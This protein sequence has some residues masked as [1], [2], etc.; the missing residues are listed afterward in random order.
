MA[1]RSNSK[2]K[3]AAAAGA[4][5]RASDRAVGWTTLV[6]GIAIS[7]FLWWRNH[8]A[9]QPMWFDEY[10]LLNTALILWVPLV[11]LMMGLRREPEEFG[12]QVGDLRQ[13]MTLVLAA[14]LVFIPVILY[15]APDK[16]AQEYYLSWLGQ[17]RAVVGVFPN[18]H[19]GF[20]PGQLD[21]ARLAYHEAM[22]GFYMFG[23]EFFFRGYLL[24]GVRKI[25]PVWVAV[26]IQAVIFTAMHWSKPSAEVASSFPG[27]ILMA[28]LALRSKSFLPC[29]MLHWLVS[30]GFDAAVLYYHFRH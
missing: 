29:F 8:D 11:I 6:S 19:G 22:M 21:W 7:A 27:A 15:F 24:N 2:G 25:S 1:R 14:F 17:S 5:G 12:F 4:S 9:R 18:G 23:W 26:L 16:N 3:E 28:I 20:T 13:G 10:N 30:A